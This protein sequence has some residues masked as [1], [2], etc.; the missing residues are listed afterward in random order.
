MK[1]N[2][3]QTFVVCFFFKNL[4]DRVE[5]VSV[6]KINQRIG[7]DVD[8]KTAAK[9]LSR[10]SL[11]TEVMNGDTLRVTIPVTR[12]DILHFCDIAEDCA[13]AFGFNNI[14]KTVPKTSCIGNQVN[15]RKRTTNESKI[16]SFSSFFSSN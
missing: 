1:K 2:R 14:L 11:P 13:V 8:A 12:A 10:M 6:K 7:I 9:L 5:E 16:F 3:K 4:T 15:R